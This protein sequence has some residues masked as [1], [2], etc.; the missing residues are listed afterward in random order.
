MGCGHGLCVLIW[1]C[2]L[3]VFGQMIDGVAGV[4]EFEV[5]GFPVM[6]A[7]VLQGL[8]EV[9]GEV[10]FVVV[11]IAVCFENGGVFAAGAGYYSPLV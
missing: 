1:L 3:D 8:H 5:E 6:P 9:F 2:R 10:G 11:G 7:M 4:L